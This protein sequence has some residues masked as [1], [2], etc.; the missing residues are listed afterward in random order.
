[1]V[2]SS[3]AEALRLAAFIKPMD[4]YVE[5][6][7]RESV[8][9]VFTAESQSMKSMGKERFQASKTAVLELLAVILECDVTELGRAA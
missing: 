5:V 2:A 1:M 4:G 6:S 9:I 8:V 7:V 3:K